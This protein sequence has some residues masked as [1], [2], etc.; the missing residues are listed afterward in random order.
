MVT[1]PVRLDRYVQYVPYV[2]YA[3]MQRMYCVCTTETACKP[4]RLCKYVPHVPYLP[5]VLHIPYVHC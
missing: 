3:I 4:L 5:D 1:S 2:L